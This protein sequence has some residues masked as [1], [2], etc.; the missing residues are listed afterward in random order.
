MNIDREKKIFNTVLWAFLAGA[1]IFYISMISTG[2][3]ILPV[4]V[5]LMFLLLDAGFIIFMFIPYPGRMPMGKAPGS[6]TRKKWYPS[7]LSDIVERSEDEKK[8][9]HGG[10]L[11]VGRAIGPARRYQR[12]GLEWGVGL[13]LIAAVVSCST[14]AASREKGTRAGYA[15][16][17]NQTPKTTERAV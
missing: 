5:W 14:R 7:S 15:W 1:L 4:P 10:I 11:E 8:G 13:I 17:K 9:S 6:G 3:I 16:R 2:R 12:T